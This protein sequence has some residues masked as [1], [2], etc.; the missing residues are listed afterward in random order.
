MEE[1]Y[2]EG[3]SGHEIIA[4]V[5]DQVG[6]ALRKDCNLRASDAYTGGYD[7]WIE[8]HLNLHGL[9]T[10]K[11]TT[12]IVMNSPVEDPDQQ[13]VNVRVD[14][15]LEPALNLVRERSDQ[16]IPTLTKDEN[17]KTVVQKRHYAKRAQGG[18]TGDSL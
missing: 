16:G 1:E 5:Q 17:G 7:G 2:V 13:S 10:A 18:A 6:D 15:P 3:L 8:I 12:K 4:D 9:D 14:I 11:V